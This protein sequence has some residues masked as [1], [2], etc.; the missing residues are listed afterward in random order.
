[1]SAVHKT[2]HLNL[3]VRYGGGV[4]LIWENYE[5]IDFDSY[6]IY[7]GDSK[8]TMKEK[9]EIPSNI[10]SFT[11]LD[12]VK[13][14]YQIAIVLPDTCITGLLKAESGPYAQSLSNIAEFQANSLM[15][16]SISEVSACPNPFTES[17]S[18]R[19]NLVKQNDVRIEFYNNI[20]KIRLLKNLLPTSRKAIT[21]KYSIQAK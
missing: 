3:N 10:T 2:L 14:Y 9:T 6:L 4:N 15:S 8:A 16:E 13:N 19:Y 11:I 21:R 7:E 12:S 18:V 1:M 5:G 20:G 17:I